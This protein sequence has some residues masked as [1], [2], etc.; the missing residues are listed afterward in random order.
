M[1]SSGLA[2]DQQARAE[3]LPLEVGEPNLQAFPN[4]SLAEAGYG[5]LV[6][7]VAIYGY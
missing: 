3:E 6:V 4:R 2:V 1:H 5:P 7:P